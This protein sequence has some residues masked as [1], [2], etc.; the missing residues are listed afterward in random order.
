M[1]VCDVHV[2]T[3]TQN[4]I[5]G[6]GEF[7]A[8][9]FVGFGAAV[10]A[11]PSSS[12]CVDVSVRF[13]EDQSHNTSTH[14]NYTHAHTHML[15]SCQLFPSATQTHMDTAQELVWVIFHANDSSPKR[16]FAAKSFMFL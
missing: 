13:C 12:V 6:K 1:C 14:Y 7:C 3:D 11:D 8:F 15:S 10:E 4:P 9:V 16:V 5:F 2:L